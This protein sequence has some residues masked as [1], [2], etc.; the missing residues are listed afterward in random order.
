MRK[1]NYFAGPSVLPVEVLEEMRDNIVDYEG[2]GL[3]IIEASHRGGLFEEMYD[4]CLSTF[5][6]LLSIPEDYDVYFLG[7]GATLQFTMIPT[8]FL[9]PGKVADYSKTGTWSNKACSDAQKLGSV[10]VFF[11]GKSSNFTTLPDPATVKPSENSAY[12]YLCANETI[13]GIEWKDFPDTGD[14]PLIADMS[15]DILSRP[16]DVKKFGMIYGGV[17]KNLGPAG[18]TFIIM[19]KDMLER[20][21]ENLTAYMDYAL[22]AK[23]KGLYNTPPV[24]SIWG[25][26]L[27]LEW[28]KRNG[29][30]EG[31]DALADKKSSLIYDV[32]DSSDFWRS[33][34]DSRY[35]S[36]MNIVF[37]LPSEELEA[38]FVKEATAADMLGLKGHRS[39][40]GLR[41]SLYN[42]LPYEDVVALRDFMV[43]FERKNG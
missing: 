3:S 34:V 5:R 30:V 31:M 42:A 24:F 11:D 18:A 39:V 33:P 2:K 23:E 20:R 29:G 14:V 6:E 25:V 43:E 40:G 28:I 10:N 13:G 19:R 17:Q 16:V 37:R 1:K 41:A 26:K 38:K 8:N 22:H 27:V 4:S 32:I 12:V 9:T 35:R 21:N 7:G 36:R 15:S